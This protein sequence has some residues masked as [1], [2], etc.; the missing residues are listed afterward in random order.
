MVAAGGAQ[1]LMS[2]VPLQVAGSILYLG[3]ITTAVTRIGET[4]AR[5]HTPHPTPH[6]LH[7]TVYT[8]N[9]TP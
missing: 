9:L 1:F 4:K 8:L 7:P 5:P 2:E 6:T 3:I